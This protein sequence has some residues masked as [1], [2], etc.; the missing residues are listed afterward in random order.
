MALMDKIRERAKQPDK[1]IILPEGIEK[2]TIKAA[3]FILKEGAVSDSV[4]LVAITANQ[5]GG[6]SL[7]NNYKI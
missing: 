2:R 1:C 7:G 6:N 4:N 5:A 3:D